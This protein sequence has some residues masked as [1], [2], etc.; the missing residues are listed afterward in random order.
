MATACEKM[1]QRRKSDGASIRVA[2]LGLILGIIRIM[3][4][5]SLKPYYLPFLLILLVGIFAAAMIRNMI[6]KGTY[7][8]RKDGLP[9]PSSEP[10]S[11][12]TRRTVHVIIFIAAFAFLH[13]AFMHVS[14]AYIPAEFLICISVSLLL[15]TWINKRFLRADSKTAN[16]SR[17]RRTAS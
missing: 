15:G 4:P 5:A 16:G 3:L 6:R 7:L 10:K 11:R 17:A 1:T 9:A 12:R 13:P 2:I 8:V 14:P